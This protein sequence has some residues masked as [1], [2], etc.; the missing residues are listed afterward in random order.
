[1]KSA[2]LK[3]GLSPTNGIYMSELYNSQFYT[4]I[5]NDGIASAK[6]VIPFLIEIF[7]PK[8]LLD[9]GTGSGAWAWTAK[10]HGI[11]SLGIDGGYVPLKSRLLEPEEFIEE[12]LS[13]QWFEKIE[14][15]GLFDITLCLEVAEHIPSTKAQHFIAQL[16]KT[17][18]VIVFSAAIPYQG[19]THHVNE[20]WIKFWDS[21]FEQHDFIRLDLFRSKFWNSGEINFWY[22][23]NL[24]L[25]VKK[26]LSE[27]YI[28]YEVK[29]PDDI[30]HPDLYL[31]SVKRK[32]L[33]SN[34]EFDKEYRESLLD[35]NSVNST[36]PNYG[37]EFDSA[38]KF[39]WKF[40]TKK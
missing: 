30:I 15:Y 4:A 12:D 26:S 36:P 40:F 16:I 1:M 2:L 18:N 35:Q 37:A 33:D 28:K 20:N 19:G 21:H 39:F 17:S 11:K 31:W 38:H 5:K 3:F 24:F 27:R 8:T 32:A 13:A 23:Q 7:D 25:Y 9:V 14:A 22:R 10:N 6:L 29:L 34:Y